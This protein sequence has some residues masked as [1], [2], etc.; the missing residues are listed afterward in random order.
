MEAHPSVF[1]MAK[2]TNAHQADLRGLEMPSW[3][4]L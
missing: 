2:A 4:A 1:L 3:E